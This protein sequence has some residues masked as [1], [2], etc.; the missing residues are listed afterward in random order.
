MRYIRSI[1]GGL[2]VIAGVIFTILPGSSLFVLLG[3]VLISVD[4]KPARQ[5]LARIQKAM[6]ISARKLDSFLH[7]RKYR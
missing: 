7:K 5:L 6:S 3:L 1:L 2:L 4:Y